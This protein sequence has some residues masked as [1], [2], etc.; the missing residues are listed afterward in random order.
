MV[1]EGHEFIFRRLI[2]PASGTVRFASALNRSVT[3]SMNDLVNAAK[4][5]LIEEELSPFDVGFRLNETPLSYLD[6]RNPR[7]AFKSLGAGEFGAEGG[8][9]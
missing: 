8:E 2:A 9:E 4:V 3:G 1:D 5:W 7:E 6:Y